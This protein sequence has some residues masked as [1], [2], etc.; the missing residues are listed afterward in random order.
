MFKSQIHDTGAG[1]IVVGG[2][3]RKSLTPAVN[4]VVRKNLILG[5][6]SPSYWRTSTGD[7]VYS[8]DLKLLLPAGVGPGKYVGTNP[9]FVGVWQA[10][11]HVMIQVAVTRFLSGAY[12]HKTFVANG[13]GFYSV[14]FV[15]RI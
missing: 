10:S 2:G 5:F 11:R 13:F 8:T 4:F 15:Y 7:G 6:E 9:G 1:G 14:S 3:D 12:L